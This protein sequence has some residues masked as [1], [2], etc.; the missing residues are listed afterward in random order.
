MRED[1]KLRHLERHEKRRS[2]TGGIIPKR[3][4][5]VVEASQNGDILNVEPS[6]R[7]GMGEFDR[8]KTDMF[9]F[10]SPN[11]ST[12]TTTTT[13]SSSPF[14][15]PKVE[16][17]FVINK[18]TGF[19]F[20]GKIT[21][22]DNGP[23]HHTPVSDLRNTANP[24]ELTTTPGSDISQLTPGFSAAGSNTPGNEV[25]S[26]SGLS[27]RSARHGSTSGPSV[28][29][30]IAQMVGNAGL[31][32]NVSPRQSMKMAMDRPETSKI[33]VTFAENT[34]VSQEENEPDLIQWLFSDAVMSNTK[35]PL[36]SPSFFES[37]VDIQTLFSPPSVL[38]DGQISE[39]T[40]S[41]LY[42]YLP[43]DPQ[44]DGSL[45]QLQGYINKYW[46]YFHPQYPLMHRPSFDPN[47]CP[48]GL[49]WTLILI[50]AAYDHS[51]AFSNRICEHLRFAVF[52][53]PDFNPPAA[54]W[55]IQALLII[56]IYE[57]TISTRKYHERAHIH[58]AATI[59]LIRRGS[60]LFDD[61]E[62]N[63]PDPWH[64]WI[65]AEA[66]KRAALM[67]FILDVFDAALFG[68]PLMMSVHEIRLSL[69]CSESLWSEY[70]SE[71]A[72][73]PRPSNQPFLGELKKTL[74]KKH[75]DTGPFGRRVLLA[76]L[77]CISIQ[78]QQR[79]L[80]VS[81]V[82]WGAFK[83]TWRDILTPAF[84]FWKRDHDMSLKKSS[85]Q[86]QLRTQEVIS[87]PALL[88]KLPT[89]L[90][91]YSFL[92]RTQGC[93]SPFYHLSHILMF[94]SILDFQVYAGCPST[95]NHPI[96]K[97]EFDSAARRI[98]G[99]VQ[100]ICGKQAL[101][102]AVRFLREM[103]LASPKEI[104][105]RNNN[106]QTPA[107][108]YSSC[109]CTY[110]IAK[111]VAPSAVGSPAATDEDFK[112]KSRGMTFKGVEDDG[113]ADYDRED[114]LQGFAE[115]PG[116]DESLEDMVKIDYDGANDPI[117]KRPHILYVCAIVVWAY[118]YCDNGPEQDVVGGQKPDISPG[119][120]PDEITKAWDDL[121]ADVPS[122]EDGYSY[123][124]RLSSYR[125]SQLD[126]VPGKQN[127]VG[128]LRLVRGSLKNQ[129]WELVGEGRRLLNHIILRSLGS[130]EVVCDYMFNPRQR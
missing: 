94:T 77:L 103:F 90:N 7:S 57:K 72:P 71:K 83:N 116:V 28:V 78:M 45:P 66:R 88:D 58:H 120:S 61:T 100:N 123:L 36:L 59:Q 38:E 84:D 20:Y 48:L 9:S 70:P 108:E 115:M 34:Q 130:K 29:N 111:S 101:W 4:S 82:G 50:G 47:N 97:S 126:K 96:R 127:T 114:E 124:H 128:L 32:H 41:K 125:A 44:Q 117:S 105:S 104:I 11:Q 24:R 60:N 118:G 3:A 42:S 19:G 95:F 27:L 5:S 119:A 87:E 68:H 39:V 73:L 69:P 81:S 40:F 80:Q 56:E 113:D 31:N 23:V 86:E 51:N 10:L 67:A 30:D 22:S 16:E 74:N 1:L 43:V 8:P 75:V 12:H 18:E 2:T 62:S 26:E 49:L 33:G 15:H 92:L 109:S 91:S 99:F 89:N 17:S 46:D 102:H 129:S 35:D 53:S 63:E 106:I 65:H 21:R 112:I 14:L 122:K 121:V 13:T 64:K 98:K 54:L 93:T 25:A 110:P 107:Y 79:D 37:P 55:V 85:E 6:Y 76:G 52:Q